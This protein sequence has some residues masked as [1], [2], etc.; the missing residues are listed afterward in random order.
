MSADLTTINDLYEKINSDPHELDDPNVAHLVIDHNKVLG[1]HLVPGLHMEVDELEDGIKAVMRLDD[2]TVLEKQVHLCFGMYPE[3][4]VQRIV[5]DVT[6]GKNARISLLSHCVFPYAIDVQHIMHG[7]IR[8][9]ENSEYSYFER[10]VHSPKGGVKVYPN[11][12]IEIGKGATFKT[13]F[14]LIRGRVGLIDIDYEATCHAESIL[15]MNTRISGKADDVIKVKEIGHL[16]GEHAKGVLTSKIA[17]RES[18]RAEVYNELTAS[19]AYA[20]GHVD[21][22]EIV[23]DN[24]IVS[25]IP[26]VK[27]EHPKAHITHEAAIGSVDNKQLETLMS[28]GLS[29]DDAVELIISGLLSRKKK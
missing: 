17:V 11:A 1:Q 16:V 8:I 29:E 4:G 22:S 6:I 2:N 5:M 19:A 9:G 20:R 26:I 24:G 23:Q 21:C 25:A 28:R 15:E 12:K 13:E 18:A 10:H 14:E 27:V 3:K 7:Q